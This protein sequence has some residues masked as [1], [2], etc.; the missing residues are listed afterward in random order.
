MKKHPEIQKQHRLSQVYLKKFGFQID[1]EWM[2]SIMELGNGKIENV[3]VS[4]FTAEEN[5]FDLPFANF[6]H[7]RHFETL[8]GKLENDYNRLVNNIEYQKTLTEKDKDLL[9]NFTANIL[10]RTTHFRSYINWLIDDVDTRIFFLNE[11]MM[12]KKDGG[13]T[14]YFLNI[15]RSALLN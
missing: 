8:S 11:I 3:K 2:V 15:T 9:N 14:E 10:C 4:E 5:I 7:K 13:D 12:F 1:G 6:E